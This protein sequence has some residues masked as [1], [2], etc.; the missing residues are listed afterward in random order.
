MTASGR[1][2]FLQKLAEVLGRGCS[3]GKGH[4]FEII[5]LG[6]KNVSRQLQQTEKT[7]SVSS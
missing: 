6:Q 4:H 2:N 1:P 5:L 3:F 7:T